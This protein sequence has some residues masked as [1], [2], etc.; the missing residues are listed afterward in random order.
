MTNEQANAS[1]PQD[2]KAQ[3]ENELHR[4]AEELKDLLGRYPNQKVL[5]IAYDSRNGGYA[6]VAPNHLSIIDTLGMLGFCENETKMEQ[7]LNFQQALARQ[8]ANRR[9]L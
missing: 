4:L 7:S 9:P 2:V 8:M 3:T 5:A 1:T 6:K